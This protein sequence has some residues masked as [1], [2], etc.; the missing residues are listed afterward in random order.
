MA[1]AHDISVDVHVRRIV[2]IRSVGMTRAD[3]PS[4]DFASCL[5]GSYRA[6]V[7]SARAC[8]NA[9]TLEQA[10][11]C[12]IF[13]ERDLVIQGALRCFLRSE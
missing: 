6:F 5:C 9:D 4:C 1:L 12:P 10:Y 8:D 11:E 3:G 7:V 13:S 2:R